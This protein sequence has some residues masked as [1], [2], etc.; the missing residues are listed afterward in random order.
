M[1]RI[2]NLRRDLTN[3]YGL[4][5]PSVRIRDNLELPSDTYRILIN[6]KPVATHRVSVDDFLAIAPDEN[7][8][9]LGGEMTKDPSFGLPAMWIRGSQ[10][11]QAESMG[12]TVVD[13][14]GVVLTNLGEVMHNY[15]HELLSRE[16]LQRL[17]TKLAETSPTVVEEIKPDVLRHS[18]L[19]Q[20]LLLLLE[21]RIP[22]TD[23]TRIVESLLHNAARTKD[24]TVLAELVRRELGRTICDPY[25]DSEGRVRTLVIDP[26]LELALQNSLHENQLCLK[27][28]IQQNLELALGQQWQRSRLQDREVALLVSDIL[29]RPLR[30]A[31]QRE[32][33][34]L[35]VLT[36]AELPKDLKMSP[37]AVIRVE[38]VYPTERNN[39]EVSAGHELAAA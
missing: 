14:I 16:D 17:L 27:P 1:D 9:P 4:W 8:L 13:P 15:A 35:A 36:P 6:G 2:P 31:I 33:P 28:S 22:I 25:L 10:R 34:E 26:R 11:H 38:E 37:V 23:L 7:P 12:C 18:T 21:E 3:E 32:L 39:E 30:N 5:V 24:P 19:H 20:V 29:R